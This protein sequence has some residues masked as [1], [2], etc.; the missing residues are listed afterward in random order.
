MALRIALSICI[1]LVLSMAEIKMI[2]DHNGDEPANP[3]PCLLTCVG[4]TGHGKTIWTG[5]PGSLEATVDIS[6]CNFVDTPIVT[7]SL[8]GNFNHWYQIGMSSPAY[9]TKNEFKILI[10]GSAL[11]ALSPVVTWKPTPSDAISQEWNVN[12]IAVGFT[13]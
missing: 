8:N 6:G 11:T 1:S 5:Y 13:C 2:K 3:D 4:S 12:W 7:T 9:L 10:S